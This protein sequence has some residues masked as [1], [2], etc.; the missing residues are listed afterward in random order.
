MA[1]DLQFRNCP[2]QFLAPG[3]ALF[4]PVWKVNAG[5]VNPLVVSKASGLLPNRQCAHRQCPFSSSI[6]IDSP[7]HRGSLLCRVS[8]WIVSVPGH[9]LRC[10]P[11]TSVT[12]PLQLAMFSSEWERRTYNQSPRPWECGNPEGIS[13]ECGNGGKPASWLSV[14]SILWHFHGLL[15]ARNWGIKHIRPPRGARTTRCSSLRPCSLSFALTRLCTIRILIRN[16]ARN[17]HG[18][19]HFLWRGN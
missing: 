18:S 15:F 16:Q 9:A 8:V 14:L 10:G 17:D 11:G 2:S 4:E 12:S 19:S 13:K 7:R 6:L 3:R 1:R 5:R